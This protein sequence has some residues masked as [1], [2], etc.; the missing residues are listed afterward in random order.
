MFL[1]GRLWES[2]RV[3]CQSLCGCEVTRKIKQLE[4]KGARAPVPHS[5]RR[6]CS[7]PPKLHSLLS[8]ERVK[9]RISN[10]A[11]KFTA[12]SP[13]L[14]EQKP[15]QNFGENGAWAY[16]GTAQILWV[17]PIISGKD[18]ATN[19]KF[20]THIHRID[21]NKSPLKFREKLPWA[22]SETFENFRA[23][24]IGRIRGHLCDSSAFLFKKPKKTR[25]SEAIFQPFCGGNYDIND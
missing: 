6:Q 11:G 22:Y 15:I 7:Q 20:C 13:G 18:K 2:R 1:L 21:R 16:S 8:Q 5:W 4:V 14:S 3:Q 23:P 12:Q 19:F 24:Y 17:P 10:L 9:L 25:V